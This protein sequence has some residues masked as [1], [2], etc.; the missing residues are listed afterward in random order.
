MYIRSRIPVY[1]FRDVRSTH[2][3]ELMQHL[4]QAIVL[5]IF[6]FGV[7]VCAGHGVL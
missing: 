1:S 3:E 5:C 4:I 7:C 6:L 2:E